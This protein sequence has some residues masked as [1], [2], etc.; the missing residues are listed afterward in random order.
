MYS[1]LKTYLILFCGVFALST[2]A[3]FV[4][5]AAAPSSVI[6]FYRLF[7]AGVVLLPC[8]LFRAE[9][10]AEF[11][12][13]CVRQWMQIAGAGACLALH[14]VMWFE[15][16][17]F[18]S[19]ASSIVLVSLQPLFSLAFERFL[20]KKRVSA[21]ALIG[22]GVALVGSVIIG[23]GDFRISGRALLG[24]ALAFFAAGVIALYFFVGQSVRKEISAV[25]YSVW[26]YFVSAAVLLI[27]IALRGDALFGFDSKT[28]LSFAGLAV[29]ATIGGQFV[30]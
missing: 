23:F 16:L 20:S 3:I 27:Y 9:S 12:R 10:R 1:N 29:I 4:K 19:T 11:R 2:S 17:N 8:F 24:D 14:Y 28:W 18:T 6:A 13:I 7:F 30:F 21:A 15:S 26:S 5:N 22:C 25:T